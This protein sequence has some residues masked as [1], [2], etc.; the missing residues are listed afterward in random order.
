[1]ELNNFTEAKA[2]YKAVVNDEVDS[3]DGIHRAAFAMAVADGNPSAAQQQLDWGNAKGPQIQQDMRTDQALAAAFH[4]NLESAQNTLEAQL[5]SNATAAAKASLISGAARAQAIYGNAAE[6][7]TL[8][9]R[10]MGIRRSPQELAAAVVVYG[11][12]GNAEIVKTLASEIKSQYPD[13]TFMNF[14]WIPTALAALEIQKGNGTEA[15]K[16]LEPAAAYEPSANS[17]WAIYVR[18]LAYLQGG[19]GRAAATEFQKII[20]HRGGSPIL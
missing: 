9:E 16:L 19:S 4:G 15:I 14:I 3:F 1:M 8:V 12:A 20:D 13:D 11:L 5:R 17:M 7:Q 6:S 18:G 10:M 2:V